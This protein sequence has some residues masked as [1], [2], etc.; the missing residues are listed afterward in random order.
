MS[1]VLIGAAMCIGLYKIEQ[2][3]RNILELLEDMADDDAKWRKDNTI[4]V[5]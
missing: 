2:V 1:V 3:L 4:V 5:A